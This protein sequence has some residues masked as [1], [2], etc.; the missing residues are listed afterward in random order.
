MLMFVNRSVASHSGMFFLK[1]QI[2]GFILFDQL[3]SV[4]A[5]VDAAYGARQP[6]A[7]PERFCIS[8]PSWGTSS[9]PR[10]Y[11]AAVVQRG[12]ADMGGGVI[13]CCC[14]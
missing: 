6:M 2:V 5:A 12:T 10:P 13:L 14:G 11:S 8:F 1:S 7:F 3:S 9:L 4:G